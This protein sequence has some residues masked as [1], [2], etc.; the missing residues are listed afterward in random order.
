M[1]PLTRTARSLRSR[2]PRSS[3]RSSNRLPLNNLR[4]HRSRSDRG[5]HLGVQVPQVS[6]CSVTLQLA[7]TTPCAGWDSRNIR[8]DGHAPSLEQPLRNVASIPIVLAPTSK[9]I[10]RFVALFSQSQASRLHLKFGRRR[11]M[12]LRRSSAAP[13]GISSVAGHL[14]S[15]QCVGWI[16]IQRRC[17]M[18]FRVRPVSRQEWHVPH[19]CCATLSGLIKC[20]KIRQFFIGEV[21]IVATYDRFEGRTARARIPSTAPR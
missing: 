6:D 2:C 3:K 14:S 8:I 4:K 16:F 21:F 11:G 20:S 17:R 7:Q 12:N 1:R 18:I 9:G 13:P 5:P 10:R 15:A 19:C